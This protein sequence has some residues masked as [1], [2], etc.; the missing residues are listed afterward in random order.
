M[1]NSGKSGVYDGHINISYDGGVTWQNHGGSL[2]F[3]GDNS[4][5]RPDF[6]PAA[7]DKWIAGGAGVVYTT[8]DNGYTWAVQNY[9]NDNGHLGDAFWY[10]TAYDKANSDVVYMAGFTRGENGVLKITCSTDGGQSWDIPQTMPSNVALND[11]LQYGDRLLLYSETDVYEI[12]KTELLAHSN[13]VTD[14]Q[15]V[16]SKSSDSKFFDLS[17]RRLNAPTKKGVYI[18]NGKKVTLHSS[19][20]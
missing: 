6:N 8:S 15:I 3:P 16:N 5:H 14:A 9:G 10:F 13:S 18:I 1:Y 2:G 20:K 17:G 7:P 4:V 12:S 11:M 19:T